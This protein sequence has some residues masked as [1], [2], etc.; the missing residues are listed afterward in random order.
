[1][2]VAQ[3]LGTYRVSE[4]GVELVRVAADPPIFP[5]LRLWGTARGLG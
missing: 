3:L 2:F 1:M 5:R 4:T